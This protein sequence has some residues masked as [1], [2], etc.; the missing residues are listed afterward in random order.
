MFGQQAQ[1]ARN[2]TV[3]RVE[4]KAAVQMAARYVNFPDPLERNCVEHA[5]DA[6]P[7]VALVGEQV[8]KVE[9]NSAVGVLGDGGE[10]VAVFHVFVARRKVIDARFEGDRNAK[11][12]AQPAQAFDRDRDGVERLRRR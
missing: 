12:F 9:E 4:I 10:E 7:A 5:L 8:V 2:Q 11:R 6:L 1:F 3:M